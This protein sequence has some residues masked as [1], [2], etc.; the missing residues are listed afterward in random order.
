MYKNILVP[1][2]GSLA[3]DRGL[4][5]AV[6]LARSL[7]ARL[8]LLHVIDEFAL[9]IDLG[10]ASVDS[11]RAALHRYGEQVLDA[12]KRRAAEL[13]VQAEAATRVTAERRVAHAVLAEATDCKA[14]LIV[15]GTNGRR[16]LSHLM[17]GSDAETVLKSSPV[18]VLLVRPQPTA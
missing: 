5:E 6:T 2:D 14:D 10:G 18:P 8:R 15:M 4:Q 3:S 12:G 7:G 9:T 16:G 1:V 17:L 13:G 11:L